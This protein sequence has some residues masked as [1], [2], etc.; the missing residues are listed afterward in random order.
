MDGQC[1][2]HEREEKYMQSFCGENPME[3]GHLEELGV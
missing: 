1:G 3:R 2:T